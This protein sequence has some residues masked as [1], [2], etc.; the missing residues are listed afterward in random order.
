MMMFMTPPGGNNEMES[1]GA[2]G[3]VVGE[4]DEEDVECMGDDGGGDPLGWGEGKY[5]G[6]LGKG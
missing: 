1:L 5:L 6:T 2:S 4:V 3:D